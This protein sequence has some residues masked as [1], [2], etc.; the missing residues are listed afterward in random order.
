MDPP[1]L[2]WFLLIWTLQNLSCV[3]DSGWLTFKSHVCH[4][5]VKHAW[6][7]F[8]VSNIG[9]WCSTF[10]ELSEM[11][12]MYRRLRA[13]V[14]TKSPLQ[15]NFYYTLFHIKILNSSNT[16]MCLPNS[17]TIL[18]RQKQNHLFSKKKVHASSYRTRVLPYVPSC[19][20]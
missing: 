8:F 2:V 13:T 15:P 11:E 16:D 7:V 6:E 5:V 9:R 19:S 17:T 14:N 12:E 10:R 1:C 3:G 20:F 4:L 18:L